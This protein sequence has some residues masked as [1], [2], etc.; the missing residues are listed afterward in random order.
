MNTQMKSAY[1]NTNKET[2]SKLK[3]SQSKALT[4]DEAVLDKYNVTIRFRNTLFDV[5][6][7]SDGI[8]SFVFYNSKLVSDLLFDM[9]FNADIQLLTTEELQKKHSK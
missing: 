7:D 4:Q 2:G 9:G 6:T 5:Y 1:Y 8:V 3:E